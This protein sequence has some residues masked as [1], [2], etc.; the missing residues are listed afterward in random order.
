MI[1]DPDSIHLLSTLPHSPL[2]LLKLQQSHPIPT[3]RKKEGAKKSTTVPMK[4]LT[5]AADASV[6][7]VQTPQLQEKLGRTFFTRLP[8]PSYNRTTNHEGGSGTPWRRQPANPTNHDKVI[9]IL[10][11]APL[12]SLFTE[13][14]QLFS[15]PRTLS[16]PPQCPSACHSPAWNVRP[17]P[18][19]HPPHS[20]T[21]FPTKFL[22]CSSLI[23]TAPQAPGEQGL[24]PF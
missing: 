17:P 22:K 12:F 4:T 21:P 19:P 9:T 18:P 8:R 23:S 1:R 15:V 20:V 14:S 2:W 16:L 11:C 13:S 7:A 5:E 6:S 24:C 3:I 10:Q